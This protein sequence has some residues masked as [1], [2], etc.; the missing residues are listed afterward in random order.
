MGVLYPLPVL[1]CT[2]W[3]FQE[4]EKYYNM[5]SVNNVLW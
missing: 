2:E 4:E 3:C 5:L 1:K